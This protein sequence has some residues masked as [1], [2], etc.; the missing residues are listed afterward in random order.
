MPARQ[1]TSL[2]PAIRRALASAPS[3]STPAGHR[4]PCSPT[5][6]SWSPRLRHLRSSSPCRCTAVGLSQRAALMGPDELTGCPSAPSLQ[7]MLPF[8][9]RVAP[10]RCGPSRGLSSSTS[11]TE[12]SEDPDAHPPGHLAAGGPLEAV[13]LALVSAGRTG[14][15]MQ[16]PTARRRGHSWRGMCDLAV[17]ACLRSLNTEPHGQGASQVRPRRPQPGHGLAGAGYSQWHSSL[18]A[19]SSHP[20]GARCSVTGRHPGK[21]LPSCRDLRCPVLLAPNA[22]RMPQ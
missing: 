1:A 22:R 21:R 8:L 18:H 2:G 15:S 9:S 10:L 12:R 4:P 3:P 17:D 14:T 11:R 19:G 6:R 7:F 13:R 16:V 20:A 5:A